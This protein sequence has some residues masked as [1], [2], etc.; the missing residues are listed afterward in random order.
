MNRAFLP[1]LNASNS[2]LTSCNQESVFHLHRDGTLTTA[3]Q[4]ILQVFSVPSTTLA[5]NITYNVGF[6]I[7]LN[8]KLRQ[9]KES[10]KEAQQWNKSNNLSDRVLTQLISLMKPIF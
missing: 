8:S 4:P 1:Q 5:D 6:T 10:G 2:A 7:F 9:K 3:N